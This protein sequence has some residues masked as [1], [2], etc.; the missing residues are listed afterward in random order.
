MLAEG[1]AVGKSSNTAWAVLPCAKHTLVDTWGFVP[2]DVLLT[3][4]D[5]DT[6]FDVQFMDCLAFHHAQD[7]LPYNTT[8]QAVECFFP[9]IWAV[10]II[11]RIKALIDSVGFLGQLASPFSHPFLTPSTVNH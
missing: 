7:P 9:N 4:C 10:P 6:Y 5:A 1:E 11:V 3:I 2:E 8:Y